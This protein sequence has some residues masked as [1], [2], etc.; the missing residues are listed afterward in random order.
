M[1]TTPWSQ[2]TRKN[3]ILDNNIWKVSGERGADGAKCEI[4]DSGKE[5]RKWKQAVNSVDSY[6][7]IK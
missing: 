4:A 3:T 6:D 2:E 5:S 1:K 7:A